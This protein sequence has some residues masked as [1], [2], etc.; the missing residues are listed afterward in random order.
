ML[1]YLL[2]TA[3]FLE[4][5]GGLGLLEK[6]LALVDASRREKALGIRHIEARAASLGGGLLLQLALREARSIRPWGGG[7]LDAESRMPHR[8]LVR[9][10]P[11]RLLERLEEGPPLPLAF[12]HGPG[13]KPYLTEY[14]F[15]FNLSHS[16]RYVVCALGLEEMGVDIQVHREKGER[17][18]LRTRSIAR[19]FFTASETEAL[20]AAGADRGAL[21]LFYRLWARKEAYGKLTGGG[22]GDALGV[23]LLTLP[24]R[25][26]EGRV[27]VW[28]EYGD[29]PD[30]S[31][32][33]CSF[34]PQDLSKRQIL[35]S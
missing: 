17:E 5:E 14:P 15:Y 11:S 8:E 9:L 12:R 24:E 6:A 26:P 2:S 35:P 25:T 16:G 33:I 27:L 23:N 34:R 30:C 18:V 32:A 13:G 21:E 7:N 22:V 3:E 28:E 1:K 4:E 29:I 19:R 31:L 20:G 10:C